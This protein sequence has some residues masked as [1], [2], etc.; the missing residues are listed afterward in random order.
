MTL[1]L[2][3]QSL[4]L[5]ALAIAAT[6]LIEHSSIDIAISQLFYNQGHWLIDK[7]QQPYAFIFY[8]LPKALLIVT[9]LGLV[10]LL[11]WRS[12]QMRQNSLLLSKAQ[13]TRATGIF[14]LSRHEISYLL[15]TLILVPTITAT[16]KSITHV[17]CPNH[18]LLFNGEFEYLSI[19]QNIQAKTPAKCFPAAHASAGFAL[20]GLAYLPRLR[21]YRLKIIVA[22]A[23]LGWLMGLYKMSIGDHFFSHT[24]V[25]MLLGW[26]IVCAIAA[27]MFRQ[28]R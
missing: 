16:L 14:S 2:T 28:T 10:A 1:S 12:W 9:G 22:V 18:L 25:A 20:F 5:V 23:L 7:G 19:W 15:L 6:L 27:A 4:L 11:A 24:L 3:K 8:K 17:S 13:P 26:S 21:A